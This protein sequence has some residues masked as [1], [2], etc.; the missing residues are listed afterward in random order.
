MH[1]EQ[2]KNSLAACTVTAT[3][4]DHATIYVTLYN[5]SLHALAHKRYTLIKDGKNTLTL[6][7][8]QNDTN[9]GLT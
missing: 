4:H 1:G 3:G 2:K 7:K 9:L 5:F 6:V 8:I